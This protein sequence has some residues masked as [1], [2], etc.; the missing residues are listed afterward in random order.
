[1]SG[2]DLQAVC[3]AIVAV[4]EASDGAEG[5]GLTVYPWPTVSNAHPYVCVA[6]DYTQDYFDPN[7]TLGDE[8]SDAADM[9][10]TLEL[11]LSPAT[12]EESQA[13]TVN[14]FLSTGTGQGSS[15]VKRLKSDPT[16]QGTAETIEVG[17]WRVLDPGDG[18]AP[19]RASLPVGIYLRKS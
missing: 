5:D 17:A 2:V 1:M 16:L 11:Y 10:V 4:I 3:E 6:P 12:N 8:W 15:I 18:G 9:R 7:P 19:F 13:I 14:A